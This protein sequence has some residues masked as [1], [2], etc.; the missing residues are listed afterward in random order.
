MISQGIFFSLA[1]YLF[2]SVPFGKLIANRVASIDITKHGSQN[3]GATNVARELGVF[4][5]FFTLFLDI[6]K[7]YVPITLYISYASQTT[8]CYSVGLSSVMLSALIGHQFSIFLRFKGGKGVGT[9]TGIYL[10]L[11]PIS[12]LL[13]AVLFILLVYK[14]DFISLG[15][16]VSASA[17]PLLLAFSGKERSLII[18]SA[19]I[20]GLIILKHRENIQRM[21]NGEERK[22]RKEAVKPEDQEAFQTPRRSKNI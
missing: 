7:G 11:S 1:A 9:A 12:C 19:L 15:S 22:W 20:A 6:L 17:M 5:G 14:W 8:D 16:I 10:A 18:F 21:L 13:A 2:G 3:I 4:W